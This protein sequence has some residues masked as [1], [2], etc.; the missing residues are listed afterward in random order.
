M[1]QK[2]PRKRPTMPDR[3]TRERQAK[4]RLGTDNPVCCQCGV[5][6]W[7]ILQLH[8]MAG[9]AY[10]D[11]TIILCKNCHAVLSDGQSDHPSAHDDEPSM[12]ARIGRMLLGAADFFRRWAEWLSE[13]G[14]FL[15]A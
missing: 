9:Q 6:D 2:P 1:S 14:R 5:D 12:L 7:R 3:E 15:I 11:L 10:D 13:A 8:H 4:R